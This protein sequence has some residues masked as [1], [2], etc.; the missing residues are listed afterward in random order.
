MAFLP[1]A[2]CILLM[3]LLATPLR[4]PGL[5]QFTPL[6]AAVTVFYWSIFHPRLMPY[7]AVFCLGLIQD[8]LHGFPPGISSISL[9]LLR[10][11]VIT[12]FRFF[13]RLGFVKIWMAFWATFS[14][15]YLFHWL[16]MSLYYNYFPL[17]PPV[18]LQ[19]AATLLFYPV[20]HWLFNGIFT[21]AD[22]ALSRS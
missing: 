19:Y 17:T 9:I 6:I 12:R 15:Y 7:F 1:T 14:V 4:I 8:T 22:A 5:S 13:A 20:C 16:L 21:R 11:A 3:L 18:Y 2:S 10:Y